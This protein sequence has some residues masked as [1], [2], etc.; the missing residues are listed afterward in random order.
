MDVGFPALNESKYTKYVYTNKITPMYCKFKM[1]LSSDNNPYITNINFA[2]SF[3]QYPNQKYGEF[4]T[5]FKGLFP[6]VIADNNDLKLPIGASLDKYYKVIKNIG[7]K[8]VTNTNNIDKY[9]IID[10]LI[11]L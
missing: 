5:M 1:M 6:K 9:N 8:L 3:N 7:N 2:Y 11:L 10:K 4:P